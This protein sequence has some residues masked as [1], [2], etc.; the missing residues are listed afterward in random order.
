MTSNKKTFFILMAILLFNIVLIGIV[1]P[2]LISASS[3]IAVS[4]GI[5]L[6][7]FF[8]PYELFVIYEKVIQPSIQ[9][10]QLPSTQHR[11]GDFSK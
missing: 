2:S 11:T 7:F 1:I 5:S 8:I 6:L 3:T 4:I 10:Q 9:R